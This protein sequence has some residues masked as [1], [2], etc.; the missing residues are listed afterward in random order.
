MQEQ[1][2]QAKCEHSLCE[3]QDGSTPA[4]TVIT[5]S[6]K[7]DIARQSKTVPFWIRRL[8]DDS[9]TKLIE[10]NQ[11][12]KESRQSAVLSTVICIN[13]I[14]DKSSSWVQ[15]TEHESG[16]ELRVPVILD[17]ED[18]T[19]S[20][21]IGLVKVRTVQAV[22]TSMAV[23]SSK[24]GAK[25]LRKASLNFPALFIHHIYKLGPRDIANGSFRIQNHGIDLSFSVINPTRIEKPRIQ[26]KIGEKRTHQAKEV[27][28]EVR[29]GPPARRK[30]LHAKKLK[31]QEI[32]PYYTLGHDMST[33][34]ATSTSRYRGSV[35]YAT[36]N[37]LAVDDS[38]YR[39]RK[40]YKNSLKLGGAALENVYEQIDDL[41]RP[42]DI[43]KSALP[44][45]TKFSY[46]Y[47][48]KKGP[49]KENTYITLIIGSEHR[50]SK[51]MVGYGSKS[52]PT[53]Q[54]TMIVPDVVV[55]K[56]GHMIQNTGKNSLSVSAAAKGVRDVVSEGSY[57]DI[58]KPASPRHLSVETHHFRHQQGSE[59]STVYS[60]A[61]PLPP[62][63]YPGFT[64]K[65]M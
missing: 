31:A 40:V 13:N 33:P 17:T 42:A 2:A 38:T 12:L 47:D 43:K 4:R 46:G 18:H 28:R 8:L 37:D 57:A 62:K 6:S 23:I 25:K 52:S 60:A 20:T 9:D 27:K 50:Q 21:R 44:N 35:D 32:D 51:S 10:N 55:H 63:A 30:S 22:D 65:Y 49:E 36:H 59:D 56:G 53:S 45:P 1:H 16:E 61:P 26:R 34:K 54:G 19:E 3:L 15:A 11:N 64:Y 14:A 39:I 7:E 58:L 5:E 24:K 48:H 41:E 29:M